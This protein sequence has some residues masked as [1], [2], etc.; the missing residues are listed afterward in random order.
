ME[1]MR[2]HT[3]GK[4]TARQRNSDE[5]FQMHEST[6]KTVM[7]RGFLT[8]RR[9]FNNDINNVVLRRD[10]TRKRL[11]GETNEVARSSA[12]VCP[13]DRLTKQTQEYGDNCKRECD[14][15][16]TVEPFVKLHV[17]FIDVTR[18]RGQ[19]AVAF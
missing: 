7:K 8:R 13:R 15:K 5:P 17:F 4:M 10:E 2:V 14:W 3:D 11:S 19:I 18:L 12:H 9:Q 6:I 1:H 16:L